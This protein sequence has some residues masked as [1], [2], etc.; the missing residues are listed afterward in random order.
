[1]QLHGVPRQR[2]PELTHAFSWTERGIENVNVAGFPR[3]AR[4]PLNAPLEGPFKVAAKR[5]HCALPA[6]RRQQRAEPAENS[7]L[8]TLTSTLKHYEL[9]NEL[10]YEKGIRNEK[11]AS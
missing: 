2:L 5:E 8:Q 7:T 11:R 10:R 3:F 9:R 6:H 1:M 4:P